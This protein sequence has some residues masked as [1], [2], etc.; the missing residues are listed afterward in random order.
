MTVRCAVSNALCLCPRA[1]IAQ[2]AETLPHGQHLPCVVARSALT[3]AIHACCCGSPPRLGWLQCRDWELLT[4]LVLRAYI[5]RYRLPAAQLQDDYPFHESLLLTNRIACA[6]F[7][8]DAAIS[9]CSPFMHRALTG[10]CR[11]F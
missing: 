2:G 5:V 4:K 11:W 1:Q 9:L 7:A 3:R 6:L 10:T 8:S